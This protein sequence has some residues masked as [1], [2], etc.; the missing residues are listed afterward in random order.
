MILVDMLPRRNPSP[1]ITFAQF[2][3][4]DMRL[5][6]TT[7]KGYEVG[8]LYELNIFSD[9]DSFYIES[10]NLYFYFI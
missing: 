7:G 2:F 4:S 9:L 8:P 5:T 10:L 6:F 3:L 1:E